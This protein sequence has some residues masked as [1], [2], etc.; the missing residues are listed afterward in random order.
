MR[1][2]FTIHHEL[3]AD[4][5]APGVTIALGDALADAGHTVSFFS[6]SDL[7]A[8]MST[9]VKQMPFPL[10]VAR[11][12]ARL[13]KRDPIDVV[14]AST[15]DAWL[16]PVTYR[17][18]PRPLLVTRSH[19]LEHIHY[20]Y[21]LEEMRAGDELASRRFRMYHGGVRLSEVATSL[22]KADL[23]LFLNDEDLR[24][25]VDELHVASSRS[26]LTR[27]GL[28]DYLLNLPAPTQGDHGIRI[29]ILGSY[30]PQ[31]GV[32]YAARA[33]NALLQRHPSV[34]VSLLGTGYP[35]AQVLASFDP[36]VHEQ[37]MVRDKY[38]REELPEL[39]SGHQIQLSAS[40]SEGFGVSLLEGMACGLAPVASAARGPR[41]I[42]RDGENGILVPVADS[43]AIETALERLIGDPDLLQRLAHN[44]HRSAQSYGWGTIAN[45]IVG[46]YE[47][48]IKCRAESGNG[49]E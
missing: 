38:R 5:G 24:Y 4:S 19:G 3:E 41:M 36:A 28:P 13:A 32:R 20:R 26:H 37:L 8:W 15:G 29:A 10:A 7:P 21:L 18:G 43:D 2:V 44:A 23:A 46:L 6:F 14:D 45:E 34:R 11:H 47:Q 1:I 25:A 16:W 17:R 35:A 22:R 9:R 39:L 49:R 33:L 12:L 42:V 27:N 48:G 30:L 40:V 31:K